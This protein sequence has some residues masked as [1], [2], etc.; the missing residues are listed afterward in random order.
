MA[1]NEYTV[2]EVVFVMAPTKTEE[3]QGIGAR[4]VSGD[5]PILAVAPGK[6]AAI[7]Q[8][9]RAISSDIDMKSSLLHAVTRVF[10]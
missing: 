1:Q 7:A 4:L 5:Y 10:G 8:A 2:Y 9:G 3:E 6:D